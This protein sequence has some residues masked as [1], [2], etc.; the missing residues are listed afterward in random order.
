MSILQAGRGS[1][2]IKNQR[3]SD[4]GKAGG[5]GHAHRQPGIVVWPLQVGISQEEG[6]AGQPGQAS[7]WGLPPTPPPPAAPAAG[8][9]RGSGAF[10]SVVADPHYRPSHPVPRTFVGSRHAPL[11]EPLPSLGGAMCPPAA[12]PLHGPPPHPCAH[13]LLLR[14]CPRPDGE[15]A[16]VPPT[17]RSVVL[18]VPYRHDRMKIP[19]SVPYTPDPP[20]P[21]DAAMV[22]PG[23]G[24]IGCRRWTP[25]PRCTPPPSPTATP[26]HATSPPTAPFRSCA[27]C[28]PAPGPSYLR[29]TRA[30]LWH[31]PRTFYR[32]AVD[33]GRRHRKVVVTGLPSPGGIPSLRRRSTL[34]PSAIPPPGRAG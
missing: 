30:T 7:W 9:E 20:P 29:T 26:T 17:P 12:F 31:L 21:H 10:A 23:A 22:T 4:V 32:W 8:D 1:T 33:V 3:I 34:P 11:T 25:L 2:G 27:R 6:Q 15:W 5:G 28:L 19:G 14:A 16:S 13:A 24:G 18:R